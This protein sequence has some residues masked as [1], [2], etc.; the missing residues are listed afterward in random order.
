MIS[1]QKNVTQITYSSH[2]LDYIQKF[3]ESGVRAKD[4]AEVFSY[5]KKENASVVELGCGGGREAQEILQHT[6]NYIGIDYI[7]EFINHAQH[8]LPTAQFLLEDL[9]TYTPPHTTD[10][11]FAFASLLHSDK[12][13]FKNLILRLYNNL[14]PYCLVRISLKHAD[15]YAQVIKKDTF[16]ERIFYYYNEDDVLKIA[17]QFNI[18]FM[19]KE[20]HAGKDWLEILLQK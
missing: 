14:S 3:E 5:C 12:E 19:R 2:F 17:S 10:I 7:P 8:L 1:S 9:E 4:V 15:T 16:G 18:I 20:T 13:S 6:D 11:I